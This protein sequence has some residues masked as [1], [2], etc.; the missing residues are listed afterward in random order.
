M[1]RVDLINVDE[2]SMMQP[3]AW[4]VLNQLA[5]NCKEGCE[6]R[7]YG[8]INQIGPIKQSLVDPSIHPMA[9]Y[10]FPNG[11][12]LE[13]IKESARYEPIVHAG[14][15]QLLKTGTLSEAFLDRVQPV[16]QCLDNRDELNICR[17]NPTRLDVIAHKQAIG[18]DCDR[19]I[20][21]ESG[22][23]RIIGGQ[24]YPGYDNGV[25]MT[26]R[27]LE[28]LKIPAVH[29]QSGLCFTADK[30]QS[31]TFE[32]NYTIYEIEKQDLQRLYVALSRARRLSQITIASNDV[33]G[34]KT[35]VFKKEYNFPANCIVP[36]KA[37]GVIYKIQD[38]FCSYVYVGKTDKPLEERFAEHWTLEPGTTTRLQLTKIVSKCC[39]TSFDQIFHITQSF[40]NSDL[41]HLSSAHFTRNKY[42]FSLVPT[43]ATAGTQQIN[44]KG[45]SHIL[46]G[47]DGSTVVA[48][49][50]NRTTRSF[51]AG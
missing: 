44:I 6:I 40:G 4:N 11:I 7:I 30:S 46:K 49:G 37:T 32:Q 26:R 5:L 45:H 24:K 14:L 35:R 51:R 23:E 15:E 12:E 43:V 27:Q 1:K 19:F 2:L 34:L 13:Y 50:V 20:I 39:L 22:N 21:V 48:N 10:L 28:D 36:I 3:R 33:N 41:C 29:Y 25:I 42:E 18:V 31:Q 8:D 38:D 17:L 47:P 16:Q 9:R